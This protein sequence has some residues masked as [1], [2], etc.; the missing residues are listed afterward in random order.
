MGIQDEVVSVIR[1]VMPADVEI[2]MVSGS[3][4]GFDVSVS[5]MLNDDPERPNKMFNPACA[6]SNHP[7]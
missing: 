1:Q 4:L 3:M 6:W 2:Q 7:A 5:W